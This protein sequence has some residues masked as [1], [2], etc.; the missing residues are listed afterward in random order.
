[1]KTTIASPDNKFYKILRKLDKK[2]YRDKN[3]IFKAEGEK[4][5]KEKINFTKIIIKESEYEYLEN[6]YKITQ[7]N[8]LTILKDDLFDE[9]SEQENSQGVIVLYSKLLTSIEEIDGDVVILDDVQ[10]PGNIGTIIRT[11]E[12]SG[13]KNLILT[14]GSVDV[15]NPKTVRATMGGIFKSNIIYETPERITE[16]LKDNNYQVVSTLL[17]K[18]SIDYRDVELK[19][20]NAYIFGNEG[21]GISD[22]F[23]E[24][25]D[26]KAIIP[27]YGDVDSLNVSV[28]SGIFLYKRK[29][30]AVL[31]GGRWDATSDAGVF[32]LGLDDV[33]ST[34][35]G[36][37][38]GRASYFVYC[39]VS[40]SEQN[41]KRIKY[42]KNNN[43]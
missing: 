14:K 35:G 18:N 34:S 36:G 4:F 23:I 21:H 20:K 8:N 29:G 9:I 1:M 10:D 2:K 22:I 37:V 28:A 27:I 43:I 25:T 30:L 19:E 16:F 15:Y 3:N 42:D 5:L 32:A 31:V 33:R 7:F 17:D 38:G 13:F 24:S 39:P 41:K 26:I 6:K 11:M 40:D 12:A